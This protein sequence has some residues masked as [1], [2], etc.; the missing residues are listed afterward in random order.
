M[1][2]SQPLPGPISTGMGVYR[3]S[4]VHYA[5]VY[6]FLES[7]SITPVMLHYMAPFKEFRV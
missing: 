2:S 7:P 6:K 1:F 3:I 5:M 4:L